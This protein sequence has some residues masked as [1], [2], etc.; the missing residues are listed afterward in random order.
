MAILNS[1]QIDQLKLFLSENPD[2][3]DE[4]YDF[5]SMNLLPSGISF[6][7][8]EHLKKSPSDI[9]QSQFEYLCAAYL[10]NDLSGSQQTELKEIIDMDPD[11]KKIF[12]L[13]QKTGLF[14]RK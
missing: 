5:N 14:P 13:I 1:L 2:L 4:F 6:S 10:E 11:K 8:K 9:S 3:R 7:N 12:D